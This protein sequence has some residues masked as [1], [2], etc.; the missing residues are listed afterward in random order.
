MTKRHIAF[1]ARKLKEKGYITV[2]TF[3]RGELEKVQKAYRR[4]ISDLMEA[5]GVDPMHEFFERKGPKNDSRK[6]LLSRGSW[7]EERR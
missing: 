5:L 2:E 3:R 6:L 7:R 4:G 1:K